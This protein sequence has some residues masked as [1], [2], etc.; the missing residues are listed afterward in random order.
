[1]KLN[2]A[3][4]GTNNMEASIKFY[5]SLFEQTELNQVLANER[6]TLWQCEAFAFAIAIPFNEEPATNGNGTMIGLNVGSID[7]VKRLYHKA[8][9]HNDGSIL[10]RESLFQWRML[11]GKNQKIT[12]KKQLGDVDLDY[13]KRS[14]W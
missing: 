11:L 5:D 1:M 8:W 13:E 6:M 2:Y 7:E 14:R 10:F 4:L 12:T 9:H 3:V